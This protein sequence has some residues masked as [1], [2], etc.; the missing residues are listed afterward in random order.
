MLSTMHPPHKMA[1]I[2]RVLI[3]PHILFLG[4]VYTLLEHER[5]ISGRA[6][7]LSDHKGAHAFAN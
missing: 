4:L 6:G 2:G 5:G 1:R 7:R 3:G